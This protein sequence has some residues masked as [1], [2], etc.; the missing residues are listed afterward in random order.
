MASKKAVAAKEKAGLPATLEEEMAMDAGAG[1]ENITSDDVSIPFLR[2]L[3]AGSPQVKK[4]DGAYVEG[5]E[6]G[7]MFNTVTGELWEEDNGPIVVPCFY[8]FKYIVWADRTNKNAE[9]I[10]D[11]F[12]RGQPLP[13]ISKDDRG[14]DITV[15]GHI[16]TPTS[17]FYVLIVDPDSGTFEQAVMSM[18]STQLTPAKKWNAIIKQQIQ[19]TA[20]GPKPAA[21]YSRMYNLRTVG[22]SNDDGSWS[23]WEINLNGTVEN[24]DIYRAAKGFASAIESGVAQ[25]KYTS[26]EEDIQEV[27]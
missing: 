21:I 8:N 11:T 23:V 24:L 10:Q 5:A 25:A 15:D 19:K 2:I 9:G 17:E 13:L 26:P 1:Q 22:R 6:E 20:E 18:S 3:Q 7:M 27:M 14:R 12:V 4:K 16:L